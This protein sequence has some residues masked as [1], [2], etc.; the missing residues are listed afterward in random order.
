[1]NENKT[2][3]PD[4]Y[5]SL[6]KTFN[7]A[8]AQVYTLMATGVAVTAG[9]ALLVA[10][11]DSLTGVIFSSPWVFI[12]LF[13]AQI[14]MVLG[15]ASGMETLKAGTLQGLFFLYSA[16]MGVTLSSVFL[17]YDLGTIGLAFGVSSAMF[18]TMAIVGTVTK[19]D[20]TGFGSIF[21]VAMFGLLIAIVAN[22]FFQSNG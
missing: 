9:V 18:T 15:I 8:M 6:E 20:L 5:Q 2:I 16:T 17:V 1:M 22:S 14:L 19:R 13:I 12:G 7:E 3:F 21:M 10:A 11:S 4:Q